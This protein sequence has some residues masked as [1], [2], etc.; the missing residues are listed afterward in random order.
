M[1]NPKEEILFEYANRIINLCKSKNLKAYDGFVPLVDELYSQDYGVFVDAKVSDLNSKPYVSILNLGS[2]NGVGAKK[3]CQFMRF[4]EVTPKEFRRK[5]GLFTPK[6]YIL[7]TSFET[8]SKPLVVPLYIK[9][10]D[11][12]I[13][14]PPN[15][16]PI[17]NNIRSEVYNSIQ[18]LLGVQFNL[19]NQPR[20]YLKPEKAEIGFTLPIDNLSQLKELFSLRDIPDGHSRRLALLHWVSKHL[21]RKPTNHEE[22]TEVR[23]YLRGRT[24]FDWLEIKG[25]IFND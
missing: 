21:R 11:L 18:V 1:I 13:L 23:R 8:R 7:E 19:E 25:T 22:K 9:N 15:L 14:E 4:M 20:V 3:E 16:A 5:C 24:D 12:T 10:G 2:T 6:P 17:S